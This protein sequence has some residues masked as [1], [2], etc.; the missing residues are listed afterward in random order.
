MKPNKTLVIETV[1]QAAVSQ[2]IVNPLLTFYFLFDAFIYFGMSSVD[3]PLPPVAEIFMVYC[4]SNV[5]N[6]FF[7]YCAHRVFHSSVLYATFHKQHHVYQG[8][9]GISAEHAGVVEQIFANSL[10]TIGGVLLCGTHPLCVFIALYIRLQQT[11]EAHSGYDFRGTIFDTLGLCHPAATVHHDYH[12]TVNS[13]NFGVEWMDWICGTQ[14]CYMAAGGYEGYISKR[15]E[16]E[17]GDENKK[18]AKSKLSG[19]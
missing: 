16:R 12:H 15:E 7:F 10:P 9:M 2:I 19:Q 1:V 6:S 8:T 18:S 4:V 13:G 11:F 5:F 14:D 17:G 3:S